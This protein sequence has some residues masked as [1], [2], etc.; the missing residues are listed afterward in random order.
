MYADWPPIPRRL[1]GGDAAACLGSRQA[2]TAGS[3]AMEDP[4]VAGG[5][6]THGGLRGFRALDSPPHWDSAKPETQM[7][8][9]R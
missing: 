4:V 1:L 8:Q 3:A 5:N 9:I 2:S 6:T 7:S